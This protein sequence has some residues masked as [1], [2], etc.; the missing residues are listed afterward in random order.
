MFKDSKARDDI[1][2]LKN[3]VERQKS[4]LEDQTK[5]IYDLQNLLFQYLGVEVIS[6]RK[7]SKK[8]K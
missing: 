1:Q 3:T 8:K 6:E 4:L 5:K 7:L 2:A